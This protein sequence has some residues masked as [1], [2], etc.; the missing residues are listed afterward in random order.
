MFSEYYI[1]SL[2]VCQSQRQFILRKVQVE[3]TP[4][5]ARHFISE[6]TC[7]EVNVI[8]TPLLN[9]VFAAFK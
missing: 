6:V 9:D 4:T 3:W 2:N 7:L 1:T 8:L 5:G